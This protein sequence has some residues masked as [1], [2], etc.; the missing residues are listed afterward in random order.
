MEPWNNSVAS[1]KPNIDPTYWLAED[2]VDF[3]RNFEIMKENYH[4]WSLYESAISCLLRGLNHQIYNQYIFFRNIKSQW[5]FTLS[6]LKMRFTD[7]KKSALSTNKAD[8][9][10]GKNKATNYLATKIKFAISK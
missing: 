7:M 1:D 2:V 5:N 3:L 4:F 10:G 6:T 8:W 9:H